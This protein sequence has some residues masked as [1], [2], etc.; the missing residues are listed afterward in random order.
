MQNELTRAIKEVALS[1]GASLAGVVSV[2]NLPEHETNI[3][4]MLPS[5]KSV[6]VV[7]AQHSLASIRSD[8]IQIAQFDT[9]HAYQEVARAAHGVAR[10]LESEHFPAVA[11]PAFIPLDMA[12]PNKG[13]RGEICWRRAG[14]RAGLG[15]LGENGLLVTKEY[16]A[17]V[18]LSGVVTAAELEPDPPAKEDACDHCHRCVD[19]CPVGA[20]SGGGRIN[21]KLCGD[22]IF[23][24]GFRYFQRC[25]EGLVQK[26]MEQIDTI[27]R[28]D[29]LRELW[30][31][32]MTGN[33]YYCF[34]CQAQCPAEQLP[35]TDPRGL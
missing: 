32:F 26:P 1:S 34:R 33:Y 35:Q 18:R 29:G 28:G 4:H 22:T 6:V 21:K 27:L 9:V 14:M 2:Q 20:L 23:A 8:N 5:A 13:M 11:V 10:L 15:T 12:A 19:A 31:T 30:Q 16:G 7:A 17:A 25:L 3:R 24:Y